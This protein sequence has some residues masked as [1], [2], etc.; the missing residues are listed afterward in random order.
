MAEIEKAQIIRAVARS[1]SAQAKIK[2]AATE[3]F[4]VIFNDSVKGMQKE[5]EEDKVTQELD[6]GVDASNI[7]DTLGGGDAPDN[8]FSY[9]GFEAGSKP[10]QPIREALDPKSRSGPKLGPTIKLSSSETNITY[11]CQVTGPKINDIYDQ[12]PIPWGPGMSWAEKIETGIPGLARFLARYTNT[13]P[14]HSGGGLQVR[15]DLP[16]RG[17]AQFSPPEKGYL[18][19]IFSNFVEN[20]H[21]FTKQR[22]R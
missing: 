3:R 9:I 11:G 2:A 13:P 19:R 17:G 1:V 22:N 16:S 12:T 18:S 20:I 5:F 15:G 10:T 8:L 4:K 21:R 7:S 14:S 6:G